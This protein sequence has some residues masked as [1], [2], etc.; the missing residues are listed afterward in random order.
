VA[1]IGVIGIGGTGA[2]PDDFPITFSI[3]ARRTCES[4]AEVKHLPNYACTGTIDRFSPEGDKPLKH[5]E[6]IAIGIAI[7]F[8]RGAQQCLCRLGTQITGGATI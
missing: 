5:D 2:G 7:A 3:C 8:R 1:L 4:P 6:R